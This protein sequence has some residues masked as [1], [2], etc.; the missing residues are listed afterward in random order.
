MRKSIKRVATLL[1]SSLFLVASACNNGDNGPNEIEVFGS[2]ITEKILQDLAATASQKTAAEF[3]IISAKGET[4][5]AQIIVNPSKDV[6]ACTVS[7]GTL[8]SENGTEFPAEN[9]SLYYQKY[10]EITTRSDGYTNN[11]FGFYPDI[12]LPYEKA[13]EYKENAIKAGQ[14][15]SII[16]SAKVDAEQETGVYTGKATI[17]LDEVEKVVDVRIEVK[18]LVLPSLRNLLTNYNTDYT[19]I[20]D[21]ELNDTMEMFEAYYD[22]MLSYNVTARRFPGSTNADSFKASIRKYYDQINS[23]EIP[24][25]G[26][27]SF[28]QALLIQSLTAVA[29]I[30][31]EDGRNYFEKARYWLYC[32]DEPIQTN[33][34]ELANQTF[35]DFH[36]TTQAVAEQVESWTTPDNGGITKSLLAKEIRNASALLTSY[37]SETL[38]DIDIWCP[39]VGNLTKTSDREQYVGKNTWVYTLNTSRSPQPNLHI[40]NPNSLTSSRILGWICNDYDIEGRL[41]YESCYQQK[42]SYAGGFHYEKCDPYKDPMRYPGTNG[43]GYVLYPGA[44][45]GVYGP[46]ASNRLVSIRDSVDDYEVL[47]QLEN[48]YEQAGYNAD[49]ILG[50]LYDSLYSGV[51]VFADGNAFLNTREQLFHLHELA[52]KGVFITDCEKTNEGYLL[53]VA[54]ENV[55][56]KTN[57][58]IAQSNSQIDFKFTENSN[59]LIVEKEGVK[60]THILAGKSHILV[61]YDVEGKQQGV[62]N[63]K[64]YTH[65]IVDGAQIGAVGMVEKIEFNSEKKNVYVRPL[66]VGNI[67]NMNTKEIK[68]VIY[69]PTESTVNLNCYVEGNVETPIDTFALKP[70]KNVLEVSGFSFLNWK[71]LGTATGLQFILDK[72]EN[73]TTL[74]LG[75]IYLTEGAS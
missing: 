19:L 17:K 65:T 48:K 10:I 13:V 18:D 32:V 54:G 75:E 43:D 7:V 59:E 4:E 28:N 60:F 73:L 36:E 57:G 47:Y 23:Y 8:T 46:I 38:E 41:Y 69:N 52:D 50:V 72:A 1:I 39:P 34:V 51:K 66:G 42:I 71:V 70:G 2:P 61:D 31:L 3:A 58:Q 74:Y 15:Q 49:E 53:S 56:V 62:A 55:V 35:K 22:F 37:Y 14:N 45:Y 67:L 16:L 27:S 9:I 5:D 11:P 44:R 21:G 33:R 20:V 6:K 12:L 30:S 68:I 40:D 26:T 63:S 25:D 29:E 24:A 64:I